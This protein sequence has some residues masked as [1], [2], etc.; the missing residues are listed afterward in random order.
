M[1]C[2]KAQTNDLDQLVEM[3]ESYRKYYKQNPAKNEALKFLTERMNNNESVIFLAE[4]DEN[5]LMGFTQLYPLFTSTRMKRT[6]LLNDLFVNAN[7]R[8]KGVARALI[9]KAKELV[10]ETNAFGITLET[11]VSNDPGNH[12]YPLV[13]FKLDQEHNYYYWIAK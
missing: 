6:W 13:D 8:N 5:Q 7:H 3:F 9:D 11:E 10:I 2:R 4:N 12:L 1:I